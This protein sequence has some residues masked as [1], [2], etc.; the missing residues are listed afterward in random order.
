M[1]I[2][3]TTAPAPKYPT[4]AVLAVAATLVTPACQQQEQPRQEPVPVQIVTGKY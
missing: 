3:P 2:T 1:N 4:L